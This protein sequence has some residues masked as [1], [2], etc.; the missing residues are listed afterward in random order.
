MI[1]EKGTRELTLEVA[2]VLHYNHYNQAAAF[3]FI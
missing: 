1:G 2:K 3:L